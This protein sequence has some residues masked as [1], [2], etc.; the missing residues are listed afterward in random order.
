VAVAGADD[1][2]RPDATPPST[3]LRKSGDEQVGTAVSQA[4]ADD[5]RVHAMNMKVA[6]RDGVVTLT[7]RANDADEHRAAEEVARAVPGVR[8]VENRLVVAE[9]GAPEPGASMI[10]EVPARK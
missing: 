10:P 4:L 7:G 1:L 5:R 3:E 6:V 8:D 2:A 9:P